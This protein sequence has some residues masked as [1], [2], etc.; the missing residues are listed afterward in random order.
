MV[1]TMLLL[2]S[3]VMWDVAVDS[4]TVGFSCEVASM[5]NAV[6]AVCLTPFALHRATPPATDPA[7]RARISLSERV[8]PES[9]VKTARASFSAVCS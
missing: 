8:M 7:S 2:A 9:T 4:G 6:D 3:D 5:I 1:A